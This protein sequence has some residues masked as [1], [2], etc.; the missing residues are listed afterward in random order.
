M[1][2]WAEGP[3]DND[4]AADWSLEFEH[5]DELSGLRLIEDALNEAAGTGASGY[6]QCDAGARAVAAAALVAHIAG[7][8]TPES[9]YNEVA[10]RWATRVSAHAR[11]SLAGLAAQAVTRVTGPGS[12]LAGLWDEAGPSWRT[13]MTE[14]AARLRAAE[15][16]TASGA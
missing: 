11:P 2:T 16:S 12:E 6:L 4:D 5:A 9:P 7:Q 1:G 8:P 10:L 15:N 13:S 3:F 14:L